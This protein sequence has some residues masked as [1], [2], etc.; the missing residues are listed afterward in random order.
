ML[1]TQLDAA[2]YAVRGENVPNNL[3]QVVPIVLQCFEAETLQYLHSLTPLPL[4]RTLLLTPCATPLSED[5]G[6][7][8]AAGG[9][10]DDRFAAL[11]RGLSGQGQDLCPRRGP[12]QANAHECGRIRGVVGTGSH[13]ARPRP[14]RAPVDVPHGS[15][16]LDALPQQRRRGT[17]A[18]LLAY[19]DCTRAHIHR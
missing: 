8:G 15:R 18:T 7:T 12:R 6:H 1:L 11:D 10:A 9:A 4:V 19:D 2:G 17:G 14:R 13:G 16:C 3:Q 5:T